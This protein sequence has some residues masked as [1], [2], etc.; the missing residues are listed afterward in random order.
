MAYYDQ[1]PVSYVSLDV[2]DTTQFGPETTTVTRVA[3]GFVAGDYHYW[4]HNYSTSPEFN[5]SSA[6]VT[7][8]QCDAS[9]SPI[10]V[11]Q[12]SVANATGD[13]SLDLWHVFN[14]SLTSSGTLSVTPVQTFVDGTEA[15]IL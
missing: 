1:N 6:V 11:T 4:I 9:L 10:Q 12:F 13:A 8:S 14:L 5:S 7:V 2:D 3:A 15:T